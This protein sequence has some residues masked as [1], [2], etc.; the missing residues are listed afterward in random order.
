MSTTKT[1]F[2]PSPTGLMHLGNLR[3]ALLNFL[4]GTQ[5]KGSFILRIEDTDRERSKSKYAESIC[6]DLNWMGLVWKEG[7]RIGGPQEP[8]FQSMRQDIYESFYKELLKAD[9]IYPCF[10]SEEELKII[11][12]NQL[13]AG[14]PP[15]YPGIWSRASKEDIQEQLD[16][17]YKPVYRFRIPENKSINFVDLIKGEQIFNTTDLDDFI[18]RKEDGSP[19]FMYANAIDD[20]LMGVDVVM[21]GDDHLSNTPRQIALLE[22][23]KL[24]I[25]QFIHIALFIGNDGAPLS[26][27]NGSL[28]VQ[29]IKEKGYFPLAVANY[30]ARAGHT[31]EDN[32]VRSL[33]ELATAFN[34][35]K[36]STS[37]S[38]FD[39]NQL[40][41]W[42][43]KVIDTLPYNSLDKWLNPFLE[44]LLPEDINRELF[45]K[46]AL[47]NIT[48][49]Y[50]AVELAKNVF[51][52]PFNLNEE[53]ILKVKSIGNDFFKLA[54]QS[55]ENCWPNWQE[56]VKDLS[57]NS[58]KKGKELFQP[59]RI[60]LTGQQSGPELDQL[61]ILLGKKRVLERL[62]KAS[63]V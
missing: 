28:S 12:K 32:K 3:T 8:Y 5:S 35:N 13:A 51:S 20:A 52:D 39:V 7:P 56:C 26:K 34:I 25:P 46:T 61:S 4:L 30:L 47:D 62:D 53:A 18:V 22:S 15:R 23:L 1:R 24:D 42:Q 9:L 2:C 33:S 57:D 36:I 43:K 54:R 60:S 45:I 29:E 58:G 14:H 6:D 31:I 17:G 55:F 41:F 63:E 19:T 40:N 59:L 44:G 16:K 10:A 11:R 49:P 38:R 27:R 50:E 21:R 48:F 37:P